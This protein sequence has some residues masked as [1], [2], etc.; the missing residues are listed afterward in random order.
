MSTLSDFKSGDEVFHRNL[1]N[2][3]VTDHDGNVLTVQYE[4]KW[5]GVEG[6]YD[7]IWFRLHPEMLRKRK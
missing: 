7:A 4:G 2:G 1:G 5:E 6:H 3:F